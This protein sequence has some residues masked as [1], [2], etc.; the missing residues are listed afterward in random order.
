MLGYCVIEQVN[1]HQSRSVWHPNEG[2]S[3]SRSEQIEHNKKYFP[4]F[5]IVKVFNVLGGVL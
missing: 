1:I 4:D 5:K 2:I 3:M